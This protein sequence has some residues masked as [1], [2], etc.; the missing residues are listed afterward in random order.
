VLSVDLAKDKEENGALVEKLKE[1]EQMAMNEVYNTH[2]EILIK[3]RE[4]H[5]RKV[6]RRR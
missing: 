3:Y 1:A 4:F 6:K 5:R 2:I